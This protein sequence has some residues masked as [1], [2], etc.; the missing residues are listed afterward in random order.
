M[1][2]RLS[3]IIP[4]RNRVDSLLATLTALTHQADAE[5]IEVIV[6]DNGSEDATAALLSRW[7]S[8]AYRL[9]ALYEPEPNRARARNRG[10]AV[11]EG[12]II[13]FIDDDVLVPSGFVRAHLAAQLHLGGGVVSGPILNVGDAEDRPRPR[14]WHYSRAF[15]CTCNVSVPLVDLRRVNGFDESFDRYGWEDTELGVRLRGLGLRRRFAWDAYVYHY[16]P[17]YADSLVSAEQRTIEKAKM[18]RRFVR[19]HGTLRVRLATG[20]YR[21][22]H[23]RAALFSPAWARSLTATLADAPG[24]PAPLRA[25]AR[26]RYLDDLYVATLRRTEE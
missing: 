21:L 12:E 5:H 20:D 9:R 23:L 4:T 1:K 2:P 22:N 18:A 24:A 17:A 8:P 14:W 15:F 19:K 3:L 13:V 16:K 10:I 25:W 26:Q 6:V 11:A 7:E